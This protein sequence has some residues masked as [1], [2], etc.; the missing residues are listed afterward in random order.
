M[1]M[2]APLRERESSPMNA[3]TVPSARGVLPD[4]IAWRQE[5]LE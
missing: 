3:V 2:A 1:P 5:Q 4:V